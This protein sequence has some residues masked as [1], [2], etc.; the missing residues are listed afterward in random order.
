MFAE[1]A[2]PPAEVEDVARTVLHLAETP[3]INGQTVVID[4]GIVTN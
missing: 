1:G 2:P 3:S 4:R